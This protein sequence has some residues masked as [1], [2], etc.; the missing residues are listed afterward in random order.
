MNSFYAST[1]IAWYGP[2][3]PNTPPVELQDWEI[4][5]ADPD[6]ETE[7]LADLAVVEACAFPS[8]EACRR[9]AIQKRC[10]VLCIASADQVADLVGW[11][12]TKDDICLDSAPTSM[13]A[14]RLGKLRMAQFAMIDPLTGLQRREALFTYLRGWS[15]ASTEE[16][17][18]AIIIADL[19][20][21]KG[22]SDQHGR[23]TA[24]GCLQRFGNLIRTSYQ[25][26]VVS[27]RTGGQEFA[28]IVEAN[29]R[30][31]IEI[32]ESIR[33]EVEAGALNDGCEITVS[34]GLAT[35]GDASSPKELYQIADDALY[36]AKAQGRNRVVS[37]GQLRADTLASGEDLEL[38]SLEH[39]A[40]VL[41]ER[42]TNFVNQRSRRIL[43]SLK[44]EAQTDGLTHF[45]TR[46]YLDRRL[47]LQLQTARGGDQ[48]LCVALVD[49]D[50]FG[51]I[52]KQF[53]WPTGDKILISLSDVI[54]A[55]LRVTDWVGRYGGEEF[56]LV[57]PETSLAN[58]R[59]A[60]ER[61]RQRVESTIFETTSGHPLR[62]TL[63][64]GIVEFGGDDRDARTLV[65]RVSLL[66]LA[67]KEGGRNQVRVSLPIETENADSV[68][69]Q[70]AG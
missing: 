64:I 11:L 63:S 36:A 52:N 44:E 6:S 2:N 31:A 56:C 68:F 10:P 27:A 17:Q 12:Q 15:T 4:V 51:I 19:D 35:I 22:F 24:D 26:A 46:R 57:L 50:H 66:T 43:K 69:A 25:S 60:C 53:G 18:L 28:L 7:S 40:R 13:L 29:E 55:N 45:Y 5:A 34:I 1:S 32:A 3:A 38:T 61:L 30:Q 59:I 49:L 54:R 20:H 41:G 14:A 70:Q 33:R 42:V 37:Y 48:P 65:E 39:K 21:F 47:D 9:F 58:A 8:I 62:I 23:E 67:A 16:R